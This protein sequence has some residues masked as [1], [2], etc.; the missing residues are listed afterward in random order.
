MAPK[1]HGEIALSEAES[2]AL[3]D[4]LHAFVSGERGATACFLTT[5]RRDG[6]PLT[7]PVNAMLTGWTVEAVTQDIQLKTR[8]V[9]SNPT[10]AYLRV[11]AE[12]RRGL[13][14]F[15][16][17]S[18]FLQGHAQ[19]VE[20]TAAVDD[21]FRRR[22]PRGGRPEGTAHAGEADY[23]RFLIRTRPGCLRAEGFAELARQCCG[24]SHRA[25]W[26]VTPRPS[27]TRFDTRRRRIDIRPASRLRREAG[28]GAR[29]RGATMPMRGYVLVE[30]EVGRTQAVGAELRHLTSQTAKVIAVD[31]VTGPFD[32]IVQLEA[33]DLDHLG[34]CITDEIQQIDGIQR[35]TTCLAVNL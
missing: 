15:A 10:V 23:R 31:T 1:W 16:P 2:E 25:H 3:R 17:R 26:R 18:V 30:T 4:E 14:A 12:S 27:A 33:D 11:S 7:R 6:R 22:V 19:L 29:G 32:V 34:K 28:S 9:R 8:H 13:G 21:F 20:E 35:T 24:A 5:V